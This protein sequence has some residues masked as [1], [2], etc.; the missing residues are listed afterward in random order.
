MKEIEITRIDEKWVEILIYGRTHYRIWVNGE[1][2]ER[3]EWAELS[4]E[5]M[6][7][8]RK[9]YLCRV[10]IKS[11]IL[12]RAGISFTRED[13]AARIKACESIFIKMLSNYS[14]FIDRYET[15]IK[16]ELLD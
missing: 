8:P 9:G 5:M 15:E 12:K 13:D 1:D 10:P 11:E 14:K 2:E 3:I 7:D 6:F 4:R 16:E